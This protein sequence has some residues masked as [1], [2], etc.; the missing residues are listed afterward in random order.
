MSGLATRTHE[1]EAAATIGSFE[2]RWPEEM[3]ERLRLHDFSTRGG[4]APMCIA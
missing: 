3:R 4:A 1:V 2:A